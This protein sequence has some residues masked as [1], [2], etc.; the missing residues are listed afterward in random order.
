MRSQ[1]DWVQFGGRASQ[2]SSAVKYP[3]FHQ[4]LENVFDFLAKKAKFLD[5]I[6]AFFV[7]KMM[8]FEDTTSRKT[9]CICG[10]QL[11]PLHDTMTEKV[12]IF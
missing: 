7:P 12:S 9:F 8:K 1:F 3:R 11:L 2:T 10:G 6:I 4:F 5:K